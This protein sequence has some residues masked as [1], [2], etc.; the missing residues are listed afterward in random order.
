M[1]NII[2]SLT[3]I[4]FLAIFMISCGGPGDPKEDGEKHAAMTCE[5]EEMTKEIVKLIEKQNK[6]SNDK[7]EVEGD[8]RAKWIELE[9]EKE[10]LQD[11]IEDLQKSKQ[12]IE[13]SQYDIY[14][15]KKEYDKYSEAYEKAK[16]DYE[17]KKKK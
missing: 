11:K 5:V 17:C 1:K 3:G 13:R 2:T 7:G 15:D 16:E 4:F 9:R 6:L 10:D 12:D 14:E 8:D